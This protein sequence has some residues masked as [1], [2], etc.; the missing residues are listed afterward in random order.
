LNFYNLTKP[1]NFIYQ[2]N[3]TI[4]F[5]SLFNLLYSFGL[6]L[7][8]LINIQRFEIFKE[9]VLLEI[10]KEDLIFILKFIK[11]H[12]N[13]QFKI[14]SF[15]TTID[16]LNSKKRF[17]LIYEILSFFFSIRLRI[18]I[19]IEE[20]ENIESITS[21]FNTANWYEREVWDM[22][23]INFQ[24]HPDLRRILT[25]Y[26]FQ[27]HPLRKDFPISGYIEIRYDDFRKRL[28]YENTQIF[29]LFRLK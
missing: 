29:Q 7:K 16:F 15:I 23:G 9:E 26:G 14:L 28:M 20:L 22:F 10:K 13:L 4:K 5:Y 2:K 12:T 17:T 11:L 19:L 25:D 18:Q 27:G 3:D 6:N 24:T 21:I 8:K 1:L